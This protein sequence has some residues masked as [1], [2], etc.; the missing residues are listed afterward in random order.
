MLKINRILFKKIK[1]L[2]SLRGAKQTCPCVIRRRNLNGFSLIELMVAV[3]ILAMAIFGIFHA[4]SAGFMGMADARDRTVATNYAREV[5]E[6]IKNMDFGEI[7]KEVGTTTIPGTKFT[8]VVIV[9]SSAN[10]KKITTQ[11][12]W[13][14]RNGN[15]KIVETDVIVHFI[16]TTAGIPTKIMLYAE[17]YNISTTKETYT[18]VSTLT[19]VVKDV[20]GNTVIDWDK[21]ITFSLTGSEEGATLSPDIKTINF[22]EFIIGK[23]VY[24]FV[25]GDKAGEVT[26]TASSEDLTPDSVTIKITDPEVPVKINLTTSFLD[27]DTPFMTLV[28][29]STITANILNALGVLV[30]TGDPIT[31]TFIVSGPGKLS[32]P[33]TPPTTEPIEITTANGI[34]TIYLTSNGT[35]GTITVTASA[36]ELEPGVINVYTGGLILLS[37]SLTNVPNLEKSIITVTIKDLSGVPIKYIGNINLSV[38]GSY[39]GIGDGTLSPESF[40]FI[41]DTYLAKVDFTATSKGEVRIIAEDTS[42]SAILESAG[43]IITIIPALTAHHIDVSAYPSSI[44]AGGTD[45]STI[46]ARVKTEDNIIITSYTGLIAFEIAETDGGNFPNG[47]KMIDTSDI[48]NVIYNDGVARVE[49]YPSDIAGTATIEVSSDTL[50]SG[51]VEVEF[52]TKADHIN[53]LAIPQNIQVGNVKFLIVATMVDE[54]NARISNYNE[55]VTFSIVD[56]GTDSIKYQ[57]SDTESLTTDFSEGQVIISMRSTDNA[58][59]ATIEAHS[60]I[61]SGSLNIPV[62]IALELVENENSPEYTYVPGIGTVSFDIIIV[63]APL[64]LEEMRVSWEVG[65][66]VETLDK[67]EIQT[68]STTGPV[69]TVF[70]GSPNPTLSGE[71]TNIEKITLLEGTSNIKIHFSTDMSD[72]STLDV[73]F[74]PN[75]GDYTLNLK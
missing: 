43:I 57:T 55:S 26:M 18:G 72:K 13:K 49:L 2:L 28:G 62:G 42:V 27:K 47:E 53:L 68:P 11:V 22:D 10:L 61:Y 32:T 4:Y 19:A 35:P 73:T 24:S 58:G 63:G 37:A 50:S 17:P 39:V 31:I 5:M 75:S 40:E 14:D 23:A 34:A 33:T 44:E 20:K 71:L 66:P 67:I 60:G 21:S 38:D 9:Q 3:A 1:F 41:G 29:E 74:S 48:A 15:T 7:E 56:V 8:K 59:T 51:S 30:D 25:S 12:Y 69:S 16:E 52:Y 65:D 46:T 54:N 45:T 36:N 6:D 70:D 64:A